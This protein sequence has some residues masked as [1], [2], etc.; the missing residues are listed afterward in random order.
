MKL[1]TAR[2]AIDYLRDDLGDDWATASLVLDGT[3]LGARRAT[4]DALID[5]V[6]QRPGRAQHRAARARGR[7]EL[8]AGDARATSPTLRATRPEGG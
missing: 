2:K 6:R 1:Q 3:Q 4:D 5:L 7:Q 8:D